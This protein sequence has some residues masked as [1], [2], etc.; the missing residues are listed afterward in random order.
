MFS[1]ISDLWYSVKKFPFLFLFLF[2]QITVTSIVVYSMLA[3]YNVIDEK[4]TS[5]RITWGDNE[6]L[7][8]VATLQLTGERMGFVMNPYSLT[9]YEGTDYN[10]SKEEDA[11]RWGLLEKM[12]RFYKKASKI[13]D[14]TMVV[15][16]GSQLN[17]KG[18]FKDIRYDYSK[19]WEKEDISSGSY[20]LFYSD[21]YSSFNALYIDPDYT[22]FFK[23][24]LSE[25]NYFNEADYLYESEYVPVLMGED[26]KKYYSLG[27]VFEA[28][29]FPL[30]L[31]KYKVVGFI[32]K[33]QYFVVAN[34][35]SRVYKYDN[36]VVLPY[37]ERDLADM[38]DEHSPYDR[39]LEMFPRRF[40]YYTFFIIPQKSYE[41]VKGELQDLLVETGLDEVASIWHHRVQK[42]LASN[43]KDQLAICIVVCIT[44]LIFSLLSLVFS[45]LYKIDDNMKN[46][47][48]RMVVGETYGGI[49]L[50]YLFE[51]F[52]VYFLGQIAGFFVFKIHAANYYF[53]A[54]YEHLEAPAL[55]TGILINI[56]FYII[57]AIALYICINVKLKTYSLAT[58]IRGNEVKKEKRIPLYRVVV[59]L[60][61]AIVGVFSVFIASYQVALGR[62]DI[63]YTGY[64][65]K[66]VKMAYV[67]KLVQQ[68][69]PEVELDIDKISSESDDA[70]IN[71]YLSIGYRGEDYVAERG[72]YFNGYIDP[73]NMIEGRFF[74]QEESAGKNKIAVVGKEIYEKYV[75]FNDKNEPIYHCD[76]LDV[77]LKVIGVM[78]KETE[79]NL[80]FTI[81]M[82]I[83]LVISKYGYEGQ[84]TLDGKDSETVAKLEEA[85]VR[86][87]SLTADVNTRKYTPRITVEAPTDMLLMLLIIIIINAVVFCFYYVSKQGHIHA[88]KKIVGYSKLMILADT[89][90][91]F[92]LLTVGAFVTGNAIVILLKETIFKDVQLF[93]IYML[94][95]QVIII[96][97][98]AVVA[99]T[100][101]LSVIAIAR[102][103]TSGNTN[104]YR[105]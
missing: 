14:L 20:G 105:V 43:I 4:N 59:F 58:L 75:T 103:F 2:I 33:D 12:D 32:A 55:R 46:Y 101:L 95:P 6:Y 92:L 67:S 80:D 94:D 96:S 22:D 23:F 49:A 5:A 15:T 52:V 36:Y 16:L 85:F 38:L 40:L 68:D 100:V 39:F 86:N 27:E 63:Y 88:V 45:M 34:A 56:A 17:F 93:S 87:A 51:S 47:A 79:T 54:G 71:L 48:I 102:T 3:N 41:R 21:N 90:T 60:M 9:H 64:Y 42:E 57:M 1:F 82:P 78:G 7:K 8:M 84:Y 24:K 26:F 70:I 25:G 50:K 97:L 28:Q 29:T 89:F 73:V 61:L 35:P 76:A 44:T 65:T 10:P 98:I 77:D 37:I 72:L 99:L 83:N 81:L 13:E 19:E 11:Y 18:L 53:Y 66:N 31:M 69:S 30:K 91:D 62:I 104:E 74:T